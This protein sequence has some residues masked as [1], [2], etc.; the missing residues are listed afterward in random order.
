MLARTPIVFEGDAPADLARNPLF[1][2][3][4][5]KLRP[6]PETPRSAPAW[7]GD[8]IAIKDP[9]SAL[10]RRQG[11]NHLLIVGQNEEAALGVTI[12]VMIS[13]AAQ[14]PPAG[15]DTVRQGARFFVLDGTPEDQPEC[16]GARG[17]AAALPPQ[18]SKSAAGESSA[19]SS[20]RWPREVKRRQEVE[21]RRPGDLPS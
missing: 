6:G 20:P 15:S 16:R 21:D 14:F 4:A 10:F 1:E 19:R 18:A 8:A 9:T 2:G 17:A 5:C 3:S 12:S 11:A 13:L 7:L